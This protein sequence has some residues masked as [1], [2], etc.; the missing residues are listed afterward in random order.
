MSVGIDEMQGDTASY[1]ICLACTMLK[2]KE[3]SMM[4]FHCQG[5]HETCTALLNTVP[6]PCDS[7]SNCAALYLGLYQIIQILYTSMQYFF[8]FLH[9]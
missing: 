7:T 6:N 1:R 5:K 9:I 8:F 3:G 2:L 4:I